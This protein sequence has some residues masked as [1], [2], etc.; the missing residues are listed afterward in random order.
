[1]HDGNNEPSIH[2]IIALLPALVSAVCSALI[3]QH[4]VRSLKHSRR[5]KN[6]TYMRLV[7]GLSFF[8]VISSCVHFSNLFLFRGNVTEPSPR[9]T[10]YVFLLAWS[11]GSSMWYN[12]WMSVFF[13]LIVV[14]EV[15]HRSIARYVEPTA[16]FFA[17]FLNWGIGFAG[18]VLQTYN[19]DENAD[20][21]WVHPYPVSCEGFDDEEQCLEDQRGGEAAGSI[22]NFILFATLAGTVGIISMN[23][24]IYIKVKTTERQNKRFWSPELRRQETNAST[25]RNR[26]RRRKVS[27]AQKVASQSLLFCGGFII[28]YLFAVVQ[29]FMEDCIDPYDDSCRAYT[30]IDRLLYFFWPLQGFFDF[31]VYF[32]PRYLHW[33][34]VCPKSSRWFA[35]KMTVGTLH[36][37]SSTRFSGVDYS[38]SKVGSSQL[39]GP[40]ANRTSSREEGR[41]TSS[42]ELL[43]TELENHESLTTDYE[44]SLPEIQYFAMENDEEEE[45][46]DAS[47]QE[48]PRD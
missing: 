16:H 19:P 27:N 12:G 31:F 3:I 10:T 38:E 7:L 36:S 15:K 25:D 46:E 43:E 47:P 29:A 35:L 4:V 14:W 5:Q 23:I 45:G 21:C 28:T 41:E 26:K 34:T 9:C 17:L 20:S 32:R 22:A 18:L 11:M 48:E 37:P 13:M 8:D 2:A 6:A 42:K 44:S 33:R 24:I 30:V 39:S 1:M 40:K